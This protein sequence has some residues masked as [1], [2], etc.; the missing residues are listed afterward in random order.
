MD[1]SDEVIALH[2]RHDR[3]DR[4][5]DLRDGKEGEVVSPAPIPL[6]HVTVLLPRLIV[7]KLMENRF[8]GLHGNV[9]RRR[10]KRMKRMKEENGKGERKREGGKYQFPVLVLSQPFND[11]LANLL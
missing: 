8:V 7:H 11:H 6:H 9:R 4:P 2:G 3:D 10:M 5:I 1:L